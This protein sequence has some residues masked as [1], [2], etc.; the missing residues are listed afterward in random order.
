MLTNLENSRLIRRI[1]WLKI[2]CCFHKIRVYSGIYLIQCKQKTDNTVLVGII[3]TETTFVR[4]QREE[5][6]LW[7]RLSW[8][9]KGAVTRAIASMYPITKC[10]RWCQTWVTSHA[11]TI[12]TGISDVIQCIDNF[13]ENVSYVQ[14]QRSMI[15]LC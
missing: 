12:N 15:F 2:S 5:W 10:C 4:C 14:W 9:Q 3:V 6:E 7:G 8:G 11:V 13:S 1:A